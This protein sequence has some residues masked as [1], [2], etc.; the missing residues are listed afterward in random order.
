VHGQPLQSNPEHV[1]FPALQN[2]HATQ[3]LGNSQFCR[4]VCIRINFF[5][6]IQ[7]PSIN[8]YDVFIVFYFLEINSFICVLNWC[9]MI[10]FNSFSLLVATSLFYGTVLAQFCW[11]NT[12][13]S[14]PTSAAFSGVW[15]NN[16][17][18]PSSR[19]VS[20]ASILSSTGEAIS[21]FSGTATL[22]TS[23]T[24]LLVFD[25]GIEV[26][27]LVTLNY[28]ATGPAAVS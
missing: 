7:V 1:S 19:I 10:K 27:G 23:N 18:A 21:S 5:S 15:D 16:I 9:I 3:I 4:Y 20:P 14:G 11:K 12:T 2:Q 17:F 24:T 26:G 6:V 28:S 13:C 22:S 25:F 8:G